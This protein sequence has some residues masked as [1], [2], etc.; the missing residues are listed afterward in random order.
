MGIHDTTAGTVQVI[1]NQDGDPLVRMHFDNGWTI[2]VRV[3]AQG[4][5]SEVYCWP[6]GSQGHKTSERMRSEASANEVAEC[7][8]KVALRP[9]IGEALVHPWMTPAERARCGR[10]ELTADQVE[11]YTL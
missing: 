3:V 2:S 11:R 4:L 10:E 9:S 7:I 5:W 8:A 6:T 1:V